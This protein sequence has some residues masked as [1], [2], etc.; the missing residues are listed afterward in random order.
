MQ[1]NGGFVLSKGL[2]NTY[3]AGTYLDQVMD[4]NLTLRGQN[5]QLQ[6]EV[7]ELR[8]RKNAYASAEN[9]PSYE[10]DSF[11]D[12]SQYEINN[13]GFVKEAVDFNKELAE[14][15]RTAQSQMNLKPGINNAK[16]RKQFALPAVSR[17][18]SS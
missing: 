16:L 15:A 6:L 9:L 8:D 14:V 18:K 11:A 17:G 2:E 5:R 4:S 7:A 10:P 1:G 3:G 13:S 12:S